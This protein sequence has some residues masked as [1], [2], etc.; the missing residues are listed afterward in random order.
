MV[1]DRQPPPVVA[2]ADTRWF[3][4]H[5]TYFREFVA[6]L[7]RIGAVVIAL[8]PEP[9][10]LAADERV[11]ARPLRSP[12]HSVLSSRL[13][14]DPAATLLR[15]WNTRRTLDAAEDACGHRAD[16]VFFPYLDNYLRYLPGPTLPAT[17]LGRPWSGL[18]FRNQ[19]L[20][21][22][23]NG[24]LT[25]LKK[26]AKGDRG[27]KATKHGAPPLGVLDERFNGPLA[28]LTGREIVPFP[29]ITDGT[30][31]TAPTAL[32]EKIRRQAAG[33]PVIGLAGGLERRKGLLTLLR[34]ALAARGRE[35]W[36]FA[37]VGPFARETFS[38]AEL[39]FI[40]HAREQ[41][42]GSLH[43]DPAGG[44]IPD[45][46]PYNAVVQTF[47]VAWAAYEQ[48]QGSSNTLTKAALF[49]K[50]VVATR[51]E[52]IA[53]RVDA[54][55]LGNTFAEADEH[56]ALDAV[57]AVLAGKKTDGTPLRPRFADY[58]AF[59]SRPQLDETFRHLLA[60]VPARRP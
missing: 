12:N 47:A 60:R 4:H 33:R 32:A 27:L 29:D 18:Y 1:T 55:D 17:I 45:G 39:D 22:L 51:G 7:R 9:S 8:C 40:R 35:D 26:A 36:F 21:W 2:L 16:L 19:H 42:G 31:P 48:F 46:E 56:G 3:G 6:S 24:R 34:L 54:F 41:L 15:W 38:A 50:P 44:R 28:A 14:N 20:G 37:A 58:A 11:H 43:L 57:R 10:A 53:S 25:A 23:P 52:C 5:P 59:H 49:G 13:D 30:P